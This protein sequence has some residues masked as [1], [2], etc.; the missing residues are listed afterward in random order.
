MN[1]AKISLLIL[2]IIGAISCQDFAQTIDKFNFQNALQ[3]QKPVD[4]KVTS[5]GN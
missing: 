4:F 2:V 1:A 5:C 3:K